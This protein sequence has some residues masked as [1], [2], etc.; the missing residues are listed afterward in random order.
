MP[1]SLVGQGTALLPSTAGCTGRPPIAIALLDYLR[2]RFGVASLEYAEPPLFLPDSWETYIYRFRL[3]GAPPEF[4]DELVL[5]AYSSDRGWPRLRHE[6]R[7]QRY[8][9][10]LG[11]PVPRPLLL[12]DRTS[13]LG[14][15]FMI[16]KAIPGKTMLSLMLEYFPSIAWAPARMAE[17]H[18]YLHRL[19]TAYFPGVTAEPFLKRRLCEIREFIRDYSLSGLIRGLKWLEE[20]QVGVCEPPSIVHLDFHPANLMVQ[21]RQCGAVLD[22]CESDVGDRHADL[23][24]SIVLINSTPLTGLSFWQRAATIGGRSLLRDYYLASYRRRLPVD[25][26]RLHYYLAWAILRR[27]ARWGTWL[28]DSPLVTGSK[29]SALGHVTPDLIAVLEDYFLTETGISIR[30]DTSHLDDSADRASHIRSNRKH[31][32]EHIVTGVR[33]DRDAEAAQL[34]QESEV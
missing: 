21:G 16:V 10:E 22:W 25:N 14:G 18:A 8:L 4:D 5:R 3:S 24:V 9:G 27:L 33:A 34:V 7:V 6:Y 19:P 26:E 23:A 30:L 15:P 11:Y 28:R 31:A 12:E 20:H 32:D 17:M 1:T 29:P 13:V 2:S